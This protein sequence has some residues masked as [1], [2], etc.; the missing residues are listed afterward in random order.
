MYIIL[1]CVSFC[2]YINGIIKRLIL[3]LAFEPMQ[4]NSEQEILPDGRN[5]KG[6]DSSEFE[7]E[8]SLPEETLLLQGQGPITEDEGR[9]EPF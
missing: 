1:S 8:D 2:I 3:C 4:S 9:Y 5:A 7:S 6:R